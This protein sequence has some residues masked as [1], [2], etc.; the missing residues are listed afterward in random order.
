MAQQHHIM[1]PIACDTVSQLQYK[2]RRDKEEEAL[3]R[4]VREQQV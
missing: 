3:E 4:Q 2:E 1:V